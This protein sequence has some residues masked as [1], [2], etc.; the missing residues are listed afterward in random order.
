MRST[1]IFIRRPTRYKVNEGIHLLSGE[2]PK[3]SLKFEDSI[4]SSSSYL[5]I[6]NTLTID[7]NVPLQ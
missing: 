3:K 6:M 7:T 2:D 5:P 4:N 1:I